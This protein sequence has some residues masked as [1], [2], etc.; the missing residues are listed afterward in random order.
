MT[1]W[2]SQ[3]EAVRLLSAAGDKISQPA[4]SQY[5]KG[6]PEVPCEAAAPGK[7]QKVDF[8]ALKRSRETRNGRGPS[9]APLLDL[10]DPEQPPAPAAETRR[11]GPRDELGERKAVADTQRAEFD[12]R[13]AR[14]LA[15]EAEGRLISRDVATAAFMSAGVALTRA[16]EEGRRTLIDD[17]RSAPDARAAAT[18][19]RDYE[20]AVRTGFANALAEFAAAADPQTAAAE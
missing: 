6:H 14:I 19:M 10:G 7:A 15:E 8:H 9:S 12:A 18:V 5:L 1:E 3:S 11:G 4:L 2:V 20:R 17:L 16:L 13:R